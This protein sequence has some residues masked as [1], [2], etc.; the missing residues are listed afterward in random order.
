MSRNGWSPTP[1][2]KVMPLRRPSPEESEFI[3]L[4]PLLEKPDSEVAAE[5]Q[6]ALDF[7]LTDK[8]RAILQA[9]FGLSGNPSMSLTEIGRRMRL[10]RREVKRHMQGAIF[11]MKKF[12]EGLANS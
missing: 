8:E 12:L 6:M 5:L 4:I 1:G 2:A 3:P 11:K 9:R 10:P 7:C